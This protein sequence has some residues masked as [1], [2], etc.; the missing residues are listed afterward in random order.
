MISDIAFDAAGD[1]RTASPMERMLGREGDIVMVNGQT[2]GTMSAQPGDLER[3]RIV[4][5]CSSRYLRLRLDGQQ[6]QLL[7]IDS[8]RY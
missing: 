5:A 6:L 7:G 4:N 3:W 2:G 1:V 8:G